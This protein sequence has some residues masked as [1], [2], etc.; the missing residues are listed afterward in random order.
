MKAN[1]K[2]RRYHVGIDISKGQLSTVLLDIKTQAK[3]SLETDNNDPGLT[4][5]D[6]WLRTQ[7][8]IPAQTLLC[9]EHTGRYGELLCQ[10]ASKQGWT[11]SVEHC[12]ILQ[13]VGNIESSKTDAT[14]AEL[15]AEY[16]W[17]F[18]DVLH[19]YE[20]K[21]PHVQQLQHLRR[22]R[23][24]LVRQRAAL[25]Q[26][27]S[28]SRYHCHLPDS[29]RPMWD[30]LIEQL[31]EHIDRLEAQI[32]QLIA[33]N[34]YL[35]KMAQILQSVAGVGK[36]VTWHWLSCFAGQSIIDPRKQARRWGMAPIS[37]QSGN[38][39]S[40]KQTTGHGN[41]E[42]RGLLHQ[43]ACSLRHHNEHY[44]AYYERKQMEGKHHK[45]IVNNMANKLIRTICAVWNKREMYDNTY[46]QKLAQKYGNTV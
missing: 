35:T 32:T 2:P 38:R 39:A 10:W 20:P 40:P 29:V 15:L 18:E 26:K 14:D 5:L 9:C 12:G 19:L 33:S 25:K 45:V 1:N 46:H 30:Q 34:R 43:A 42:I 27:R 6:Q 13:R 16:S 24:Y 23:K 31:S 17:R 7:G 3:Q 37:N 21:Q 22:E 11:L 8:A 44:K 41:R 36:V 28:E 4:Q